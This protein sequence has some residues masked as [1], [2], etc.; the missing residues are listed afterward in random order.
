MYDLSDLKM[1]DIIRCG[2]E[3]RAL[4]Q[5]V[6]SMEDAAN[7][8]VQYLFNHFIDKKTGEKSCALVRFF[9]T[10]DIDNL[11]EN[12]QSFARNCL[13]EKDVPS[14]FKCLTLLATAG[15]EDAWQCREKSKRHQA[16]PLPSK[17]VVYRIPMIRNLIKQMGLDIDSVINPD[18][19]LL[20]DLS[21]KTFNI[22]HVPDAE[23]SDYIPAQEDFIKPYGIKSVLGFGGI[24]PSGNVFIVI[25]FSKVPISREFAGM[26]N[27]L[28]LNVKMLILPFENSVFS[29]RI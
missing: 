24:L 12:L 9:K 15:M 25:M 2:S 11:P 26:F 7:Q 23:N 5:N 13:L 10:H 29:S 27:T 16:I 21:Q 19:E 28:A 14:S 3:I 22:F 4:R 6:K 8:L 20:R 18:P 17:E 1:S